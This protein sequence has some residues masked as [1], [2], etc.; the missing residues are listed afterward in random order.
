VNT[1]TESIQQAVWRHAYFI[2]YVGASN[3]V[4]VARTLMEDTAELRR[5]GLDV[6]RHVALRAMAGHLAYLYG[7]G[8]G[9]KVDD[10]DLVLGEAKRHGL[11]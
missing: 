3:P 8:L 7:I 6:K 5:T 1:T 11:V 9:P 4:A 10:L 2:A